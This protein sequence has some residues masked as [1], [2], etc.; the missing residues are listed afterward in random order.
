VTGSLPPRR[1]PDDI[2]DLVGA[3]V[4]DDELEQLREAD[5]LL[6]AVS[7]PPPVI[8]SSLGT[9]VMGL[10]RPWRRRF[11]PWPLAIAAAASVAI[12]FFALGA[13][14]GAGEF[15][16][17]AAIPMEATEE[18]PGASAVIRLGEAD[19][20]GNWPLRLE[21]RGLPQLPP[22]AY[23]ILWLARDGEYGGTC[24]TFRVGEDGSA[25]IEMNAS[26]RLEDFDEWVV[27]ARHP[28][29]PAEVEPRRLLEADVRPQPGSDALGRS[30]PHELVLEL[31]GA[32]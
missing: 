3:D 22:R 7:P 24:G 30:R 9:A 6:R 11:A 20:S 31:G 1:P 16:E 12:L 10:A 4:A 27:T 21:V 23:Y 19:A 14:V 25:D 5:A 2:R 13:W 29:D 8:P 28:D 26:Y 18:A 15:V 32:A 17:R